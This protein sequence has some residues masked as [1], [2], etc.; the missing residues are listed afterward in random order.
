[1]IIFLT[2]AAHTQVLRSL[3]GPGF[4]TPLPEIKVA[5][6]EDVL[7]RSR[8]PMATYVF[9]D[10]ERLSN[11]ELRAVSS[12]HVALAAMGVRVLNNPARVRQRYELLR[13]LFA[14]GLNPFNVHRADDRPRP[15][16]F[17]VFLRFEGGH[18]EPS[19][20]L[21]DDQAALDAE[22]A[23]LQQMGEPL[24]GLLAVECVP[25]DMVDGRW[26]KWG[27]F[28]IGGIPVLDHIAVD[29]R[30]MV[31]TGRWEQLT[32]EIVAEEHRAVSE[33]RHAEYVRA[34]FGIAGIDFGRADFALCGRK[35][36]LFEINTA[37]VIHDLRPDPHVL[38]QETMKAARE[39]FSAALHL[40]DTAQ[41]GV[42]EVPASPLLT[43]CRSTTPGATLC[44]RS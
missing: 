43:A 1:M 42:I 35:P 13:E 2:T 32:P 28:S 8:L 18:A 14:M 19:V 7:R 9:S 5:S 20:T 26:H 25:S 11:L 31:K 10:L 24:K 38:R 22:L 37:P 36:V 12:L 44:P 41:K 29:D 30:W 34:M 23:R 33:N 21:L 3:S 40:L 39:A 17:P 15:E 16:R 27:A 4:G 6:Y